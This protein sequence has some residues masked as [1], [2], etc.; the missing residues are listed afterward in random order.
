VDET[1]GPEGRT[2]GAV[3]T[4]G[5]RL[6]SPGTAPVPAARESR[7]TRTDRRLTCAFV[8]LLV[9]TQRIGFPYGG[10]AVS[11]ALPLTYLFVG[12]LVV[13]HRM[14]VARVRSELYW[15]ALALVLTVTVLVALRGGIFS[16]DSL[17]LL[18][19]IYLPWTM[20]LA[21]DGASVA[22]AAGRAFVDLM[23]VLAVI[24][25]AQLATQLTGIWQYRDYVGEAVPPQW[26]VPDYNTSIPLVWD[27]PHFKS[28]A[29]VLLEPSFLSQF[30]ALAVLLGIVLHVRAWKLAVLVAGLASA[31]SGTGIVLLVVGAIL[32]LVRARRRIRPKYVAAAGVAVVLVLLSPV[33]PL[34]L[35][36]SDELSTPGSS[37]N[38]RFIA[39][40]SVVATGLAAEPE[41]YLVGDGAGNEQV[42]R[43]SGYDEAR[44]ANYSIIPKLT[45]EYGVVAGGF[46]V[47]FLL[48]AMLDRAPWRVVPGALVL[49]TFVLSGALL[50]PQ[51]ASLA[52]IF[53][54]FGSSD[55]PRGP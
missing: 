2:R 8:V 13:R 55:R 53:T 30:C 18:V 17:L 1:T 46:F 9:L 37:G 35:E 50:Q 28:N 54:G 25:V 24:G 15:F 44:Y 16:T 33:T 22:R 32:L 4:A 39:P 51:T 42:L 36:R 43:W 10:T 19:S 48:V 5:D 52:W 38:G 31:V 23:V 40:Y 41:R 3:A 6:A 12:A 11:L 20:R 34:L 14:G 49:M 21:S 7:A 26:Q 27:S 45:F 47:L 29:F